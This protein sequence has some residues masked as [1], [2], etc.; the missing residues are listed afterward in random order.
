M[1]PPS[2]FPAS[3]ISLLAGLLLLL[4]AVPPPVQPTVPPGEQ[5]APAAVPDWAPLVFASPATERRQP[6]LRRLRDRMLAAIEARRIAGVRA[7]MAPTVRDQTEEVP[8]DEIL[9]SFGPL[10]PG[11]PLSEEWQALEQALRLGGILHDGLYVVPFIERDAPRWKARIERLFIAGQDVPLHSEPD[12]SA[13][14][15]TRVSHALV[16]EAVGMPTRAGAA[17][18]V[19]PDWTPVVGPER[20]LAWVCTTSTRPVS[21]LYYGF[22]RVGRAWKLTR[23][24]SLS[25]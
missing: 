13:V 11:Q 6:E 17:G 3:G 8:A 5:G 19:C 22:A 18:A 4:Q 25:E 1:T 7:L 14:V 21:G 2:G 16:Q 9:A 10:T 24:Y 23:I 20:R 15:V 12:P